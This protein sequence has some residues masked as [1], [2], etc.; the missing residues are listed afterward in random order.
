VRITTRQD[1]SRR[2]VLPVLFA[3]VVAS[4]TGCTRPAPPLTQTFDSPE[5]LAREVLSRLARN[6]R[7]GLQALALTRDEFEAHVYPK[8]PASRP[9]RN[10]SM[11]FVWGRLSQQ[12]ELSLAATLARHGGRSYT[13]QQVVFEGESTDYESFTVQRESVLVVRTPEGTVERLE[14]FG[15]MMVKDGR[16]K[17][18]SYV[19]D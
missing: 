8:L 9:E 17:V 4:L 12:S 5:S 16:C 6:D 7:Q 1:C 19:T 11:T 14:V 15:S 2:A 18:F 13:L 10:T 3:V